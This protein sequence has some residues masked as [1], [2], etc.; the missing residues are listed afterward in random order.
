[1]MELALFKLSLLNPIINFMFDVLNDLEWVIR[2]ESPRNR[3]RVAPPNLLEITRN[4]VKQINNY[5]A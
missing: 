2:Q 3:L 5:R 4:I 1:M